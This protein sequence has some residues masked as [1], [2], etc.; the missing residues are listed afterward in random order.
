[1]II[2]L[3]LTELNVS[4]LGS[5]PKVKGAKADGIALLAQLH[6]TDRASSSVQ[7]IEE[8][9]TELVILQKKDHYDDSAHSWLL[10]VAIALSSVAVPSC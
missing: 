8:A 1:M 6:S 4:T 9:G 7:D 5:V 10:M 2:V 3:R